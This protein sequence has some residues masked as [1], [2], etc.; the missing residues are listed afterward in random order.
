MQHVLDLCIR[1]TP[2]YVPLFRKQKITPVTYI[3]ILIRVET[4]S[5]TVRA[6]VFSWVLTQQIK[7]NTLKNQKGV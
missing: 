6:V 7:S 3:Y 5:L 2:F 4:F 1:H